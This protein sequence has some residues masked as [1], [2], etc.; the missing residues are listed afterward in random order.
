MGRNGYYALSPCCGIELIAKIR[1]MI[2][3]Y[4]KCDTEYRLIESSD[5][6]RGI[7]N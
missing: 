3:I 7:K 6:I 5:S 2:L 1:N 4:E